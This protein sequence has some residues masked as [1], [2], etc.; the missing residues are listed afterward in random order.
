MS[1]PWSSRQAL[2]GAFSTVTTLPSG[3]SAR[4]RAG[5]DRP[6][7]EALQH[8]EARVAAEDERSATD[9]VRAEVAQHER[10][11]TAKDGEIERLTAALAE[12]DQAAAERTAE[13]DRLTGRIGVGSGYVR[14]VVTSREIAGSGLSKKAYLVGHRKRFSILLKT[15]ASSAAIGATI[16]GHPDEP[17]EAGLTPGIWRSMGHSTKPLL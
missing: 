6:R 15:C 8:D 17:S 4:Q 11:I 14:K 3:K 13:I 10:A 1:T 16:Y 5:T 9:A 2:F 12:R 7:P